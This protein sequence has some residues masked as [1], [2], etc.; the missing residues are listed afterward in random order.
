MAPHPTGRDPPQLSPDD[1][2]VPWAPTAGPSGPF[3]EP[4]SPAWSQETWLWTL[5]GQA[6]LCGRENPCTS[7]GWRRRWEA[8]FPDSDLPGSVH[9]WPSLGLGLGS[10]V[11][12]PAASSS[13]CRGGVQA[14]DVVAHVPSA[15]MPSLPHWW[16]QARGSGLCMCG[17]SV[18]RGQCPTASARG[19]ASA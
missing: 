5:A 10:D 8:Q 16:P 18:W 14:G 7:L 15:R 2:S 3:L 11:L 9:A 19:W 12:L 17:H 1:L 6:V 4:G 13:P